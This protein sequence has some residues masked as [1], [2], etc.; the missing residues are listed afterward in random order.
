MTWKVSEKT[1]KEFVEKNILKHLTSPERVKVEPKLNE[2]VEKYKD[3]DEI[4]VNALSVMA[5]AA[6][7]GKLSEFLTRLDG[8]FKDDLNFQH[9]DLRKQLGIKKQLFFKAC[10]DDLGIKPASQR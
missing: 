10:Y 3:L 6:E 9:P 7:R 4:E 8:Q 5:Y 2:V 1:R